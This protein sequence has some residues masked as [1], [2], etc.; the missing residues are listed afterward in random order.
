MAKR[1]AY[2]G[3]DARYGFRGVPRPINGSTVRFPARWSRYYP[4]GY[5]PE[6]WA[7]LE[8]ACVPGSLALDLGAHL[9]LF[10]VAMGRAVGP[11]GRVLA[12]EPTERTRAAL[13]QT[14]R[15]NGLESV[16]EVR[17]EALGAADGTGWFADEGLMSNRNHLTAVS[18]GGAPVTIA[19]VDSIVAAG[20]GDR[21]VSC[22][23][24]DIEGGEVDALRGAERTIVDHRPGLAIEVHPPVLRQLGVPLDAVSA[25]LDE[26]GYRAVVAGQVID[27]EWATQQVDGY[28]LQAVPA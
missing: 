27:R 19:S 9:G 25:L 28:E 14:V 16:V 3:L 15:L 6:K 26:W 22:L 18:E 21:P 5:E 11:N 20:K 10:S 12:F 23:K 17:G 8:A 7:F 1:A 24:I 2:T 4:A 13:T